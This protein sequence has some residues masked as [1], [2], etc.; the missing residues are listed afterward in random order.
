MG[1]I[2]MGAMG[3]G[4]LGYATKIAGLQPV[5]VCDVWQPNLERAEAQARKGGL[6]GQGREGFSRDPGG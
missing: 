1:W 4:N 3:S 6:R 2:G 5:A